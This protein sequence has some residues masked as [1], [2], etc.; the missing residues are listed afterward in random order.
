MRDHYDS[1]DADDNSLLLDLSDSLEVLALVADLEDE[2][3]VHVK[4]PNGIETVG[5]LVDLFLRAFNG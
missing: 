3:Q 2:F 1:P 4:L 5:E